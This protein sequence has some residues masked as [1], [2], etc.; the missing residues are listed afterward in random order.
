MYGEID[1][2][3]KVGRG[4][5]EGDTTSPIYFNVGLESVFRLADE[6]NF[7]VTQLNYIKVKNRT[8]YKFGFTYDVRMLGGNND[9]LS[10]TLQNI[11]VASEP[12]GLSI[13]VSKSFAQHID[14][15]TEASAVTSEDMTKLNMNV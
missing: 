5:L 8:L 13:S 10:T 14:K 11:Q 3:V 4:A 2:P 1:G 9:R 6:L 12:A 7:V 15:H